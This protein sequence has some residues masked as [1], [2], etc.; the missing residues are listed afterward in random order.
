MKNRNILLNL[1][2]ILLVGVS[3]IGA[4]SAHYNQYIDAGGYYNTNA[5]WSIR[6]QN[7][8]GHDVVVN[9]DGTD[10]NLRPIRREEYG[11]P[12]LEDYQATV[13]VTKDSNIT[14]DGTTISVVVTDDIAQ[15]IHGMQSPLYW[16]D[17]EYHWVVGSFEIHGCPAC[18]V[19]CDCS[20]NTCFR[21][22]ITK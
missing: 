12:D 20:N 19:G 14:Y 16:Q 13:N 6:F 15:Y 3:T 8:L 9:V 1:L 11:R 2:I 18:G 17:H 4:V 5:T 7:Q 22:M 21:I 10:Y